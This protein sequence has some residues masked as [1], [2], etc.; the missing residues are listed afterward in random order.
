MQNVP[1]FDYYLSKYKTLGELGDAFRRGTEEDSIIAEDEDYG[2]I[3]RK[4]EHKRQEDIRDTVHKMCI[5]VLWGY[6]FVLATM[7]VIW[8]IHLVSP[9][10]CPAHY[11][12]DDQ[13]NIM[14]NFIFSGTL[15]ALLVSNI[16][17]RL[18]Q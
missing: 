3:T 2:K 18:I 11:L 10:S 14:Q 7:T 17:S 5:F 13:L 6:L 12:S 9:L 1:D 16:K 8:L 4:N 15:S